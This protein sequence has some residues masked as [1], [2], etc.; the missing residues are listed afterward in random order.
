MQAWERDVKMNTMMNHGKRE[1]IILGNFIIVHY[2]ILKNVKVRESNDR[3]D[4]ILNHIW[5]D[6]GVKKN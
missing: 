1:I 4:F 5:S 6:L 3:T 2:D